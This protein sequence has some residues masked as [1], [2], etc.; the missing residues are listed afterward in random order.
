MYTSN[1][2]PE[3]SNADWARLD[4][5]QALRRVT[6]TLDGC[7]GRVEVTPGH[8]RAALNHLACI[9]RDARKA[10]IMTSEL[11]QRI[12]V[13]KHTAYRVIDAR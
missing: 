2:M 8:A 7:D 1:T 4:A 9:D 13:R 5:G 3:M 11:R 12:N 10:G 6:S